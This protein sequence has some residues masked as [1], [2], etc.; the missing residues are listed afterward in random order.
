MSKHPANLKPAP[1]SYSQI[2]TIEFKNEQR[3]QQTKRYK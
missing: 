2:I 3:Q 1:L